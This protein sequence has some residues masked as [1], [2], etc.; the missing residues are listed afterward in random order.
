MRD[1]IMDE[2]IEM[3]NDFSGLKEWTKT[4]KIKFQRNQS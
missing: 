4:N 1:N 3:K 2:R